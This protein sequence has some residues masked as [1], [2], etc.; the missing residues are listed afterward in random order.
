MNAETGAKRGYRRAVGSQ[1]AAW[2]RDVMR[3]ARTFPLALLLA[4]LSPTGVR[5]AEILFFSTDALA[6]SMRELVPRFEKDS[7]HSVK[8]TVANAGT[9]AA[10]LQ[11]GEPADLAFVLPPAWDRLRSDGRIDPAVR[12]IVGKVGLGAFVKRG[13]NKPDIGTVESFK[14]AL[15]AAKG[16]GI[17]D[18]AQRSPVGTYMLALFDRLGLSDALKPKLVLTVHP[19][20][21][22]VLGAVDS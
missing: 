18:P 4:L 19:P 5:A 2:W 13:A 1:K 6:S 12:T 17:R 9:I 8:M 3:L 14:R 11:S 7:G 21:E 10:R 16:V 20:Y 22:E 15:L